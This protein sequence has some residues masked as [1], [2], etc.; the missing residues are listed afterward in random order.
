MSLRRSG[1]NAKLGAIK[2]IKY[3]WPSRIFFNYLN[4]NVNPSIAYSVSTRPTLLYTRAE[5]P[6][7]QKMEFYFPRYDFWMVLKGPH[8]FHG[9]GA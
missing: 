7:V 9:H 6:L 1:Y 4:E 2:S 5:G 8:I 3:P